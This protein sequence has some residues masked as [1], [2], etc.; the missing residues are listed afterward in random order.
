MKHTNIYIYIL[1]EHDSPFDCWLQ[2]IAPAGPPITS[3]NRPPA[4]GKYSTASSNIYSISPSRA[5]SDD[6]EDDDYE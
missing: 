3:T 5:I 2:G 4:A 1:N 6:Y